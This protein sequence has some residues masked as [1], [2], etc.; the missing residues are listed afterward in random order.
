MQRSVP[1]ALELTVGWLEVEC[2][3]IAGSG[4]PSLLARDSQPASDH[5]RQLWL[6]EPEC[7]GLSFSGGNDTEMTCCS[8]SSGID[9]TSL[10]G[11]LPVGPGQARLISAGSPRVW[12][13]LPCHQAREN[14][15]TVQFTQR[16]RSGRDQNPGGTCL[17]GSMGLL[18]DYSS[19]WKD[20]RRL[21]L[22]VLFSL[23]AQF[24]E[25]TVAEVSME[26]EM[27]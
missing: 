10:Q 23:F 7:R 20:D 26:L 3:E 24:R 21:W 27:L 14:T 5:E 17:S 12:R 16:G 25:H 19:E 13:D 22:C 9:L 15:E 6:C 4:L 8:W 2:L 1:L 11:L 18:G